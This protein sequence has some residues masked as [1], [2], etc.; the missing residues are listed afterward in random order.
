VNLSVSASALQDLEE[1][2]AWYEREKPGLGDDLANAFEAAAHRI[3]ERPEIGSAFWIDERKLVMRRFPDSVIY[4]VE[5]ETV[6]VLAFAH[7]RRKP[8]YWRDEGPG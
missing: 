4:R 7:H 2:A 5:D 3:R 1:A 8:G 6:F